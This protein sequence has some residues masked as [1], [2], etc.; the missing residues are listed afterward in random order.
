[1]SQGLEVRAEEAARVYGEILERLM[2]K[3]SLEELSRVVSP[4]VAAGLLYRIV[5]SSMREAVEEVLP[6][7]SV[8]DPMDAM[9]LCYRLF[10]AAG[11]PFEHEVEAGNAFRVT[12]CPHYRFTRDNPLACVAC[13][14]TKAGALE[15]LT[16]K[17]VAVRLEDGTWLGPRDAEI[18]VERT[19]HMPSGDPYC[20]FVLHAPGAPKP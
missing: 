6:R 7:G 14:A 15:A 13:A 11:Q 19:H 2:F 4:R 5:R 12:R 18:V 1:M 8:A 9:M 17:K 10:E 3:H 16:G 20:R